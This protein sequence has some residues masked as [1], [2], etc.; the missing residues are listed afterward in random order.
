MARARRRSSQG[1]RR[2]VRP[3]EW[4]RGFIAQ[5]TVLGTA[6]SSAAAFNISG[7][8]PFIAAM[9]SPTIVRIRGT[10]SIVSDIAGGLAFWS[11]G[12][13]KTSLKAFGVGITA[14]PIPMVDDADWQWFAGGGIGD[15]AV[16]TSP[17]PQ[18]DVLN[19]P[20]DTKSMRRYE[21][22]DEIITLVLANNTGIIGDDITFR[23]AFSILVK[24]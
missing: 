17:Q 23:C 13:V 5:T 1:Q 18:E 20:I 3:V 22:D 9:T 12:F 7:G 15:A 14:I 21:Q 2:S 8:F 16:I 4:A 24:E 19:V 10:L 11:A 6:G